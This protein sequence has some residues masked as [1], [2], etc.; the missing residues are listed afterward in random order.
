MDPNG[1]VRMGGAT[2][3]LGSYGSAGGQANIYVNSLA[4]ALPPALRI[5]AVVNAASVLDGPISAG[6]TIVV[7]GAGFGTDAQLLIGGAAVP[8]ISVAST[9]ITATVPMSMALGG[10]VEV[11]VQS[12]GGSS[13]KVLMPLAGASPGIFSQDGSGYGQAYVLNQD[14]TLNRPSDPTAPGNQITIF[15]T[16]VGPVSITQGNAATQFPVSVFFEGQAAT[17]IAAAV[18]P[19]DGL[20]GNVYQI[21]VTVP[22]PPTAT[23]Y[24]PYFNMQVDGVSSQNG[25]AISITQ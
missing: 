11:Q 4:L 25:I 1:T 23:P 21:T 20:P 2:G 7:Q 17:N 24:N 9:S 3:S 15:A 6:E 14:G 16:G 5:D 10:A 18:G 12:G 19:V 22:N 8:A 13:N